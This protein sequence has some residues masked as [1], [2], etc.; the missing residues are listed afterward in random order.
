MIQPGDKIPSVPVKLVDANGITDTT[1]DA[2]LGHGKV[3]PFGVP[4]AFTPTCDTSHLPGLVALQAKVAS[5]P[6][7]AAAN[8]RE[9]AQG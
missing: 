2:V 8:Q 6:G 4:G 5:M 3:V 9:A 1:S 7:V